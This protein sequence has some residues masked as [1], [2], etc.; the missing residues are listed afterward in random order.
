MSSASTELRLPEHFEGI[1]IVGPR[2]VSFRKAGVGTPIWV[3]SADEGEAFD[4]FGE[5]RIEGQ[6]RIHT[7]EGAQYRTWFNFDKCVT[8]VVKDLSDGSTQVS[9]HV[10]GGWNLARKGLSVQVALR[11]GEVMSEAAFNAGSESGKVIGKHFSH[12]LDD[13]LPNLYSRPTTLEIHAEYLDFR[14]NAIRVEVKIEAD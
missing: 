3:R 9:S 14:S 5:L 2:E 6:V 10:D 4:F 8:Y 7:P 1:V 13:L 11:P 12:Q